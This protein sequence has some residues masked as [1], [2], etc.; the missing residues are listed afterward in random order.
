MSAWWV[1]SFNSNV[2]LIIFPDDLSVGESMVLRLSTINV[3]MY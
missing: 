1:M 2:S 3:Y